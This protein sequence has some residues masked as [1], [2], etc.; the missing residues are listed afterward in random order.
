V[1]T[2]CIWPVVGPCVH[3]NEPLVSI[4]GEEFV[5][6]SSDCWLLKKDSVPWS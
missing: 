1:W 4:K 3:R 5:D 6:W 2:G